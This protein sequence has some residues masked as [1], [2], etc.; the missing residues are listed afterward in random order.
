MINTSLIQWGEKQ[1][2][3]TGKVMGRIGMYIENPDQSVSKKNCEEA[4]FNIYVFF[5]AEGPIASKTHTLKINNIQKDVL[6]IE[7][8]QN[9]IYYENLVVDREL[10]DYN[11]KCDIVLSDV[12]NFYSDFKI[13]V[14]DFF[15]SN[16]SKDED[17]GVYIYGISFTKINFTKDNIK[18][19]EEEKYFNRKLRIY[20]DR[21]LHNDNFYKKGYE[22]IGFGNY[23]FNDN[24]YF[25]ITEDVEQDEINLNAEYK[26]NLYNITF[27]GCGGRTEDNLE[28]VTV[29]NFSENSIIP[30][31]TRSL[32]N[33]AGWG[34]TSFD[35]TAV[36]VKELDLKE[37]IK[38]YALWEPI[39]MKVTYD[40]GVADNLVTNKEE[41]SETDN[42]SLI[43]TVNLTKPIASEQYIF[44][45]WVNSNGDKKF[46]GDIL[47][48]D[49][50]DEEMS[51]IK[52]NIFIEDKYVTEQLV[53]QWE[54]PIYTATYINNSG[55][56]LTTQN[57]GY[58]TGVVE[59][60][61]EA[62]T[63]KM[64]DKKVAYKNGDK[65]PNHD[66]TLYAANYGKI[67][68]AYYDGISN[69][70][71]IT[72]EDEVEF[73]NA[74]TVKYK[75]KDTKNFAYSE[76]NTLKFFNYWQDENNNIYYA[77]GVYELSTTQNYS[78][79]AVYSD[80]RLNYVAS[81][82]ANGNEELTFVA[83]MFKET[84]DNDEKFLQANYNSGNY[85][86]VAEKF[87][88]V[89]GS[90]F[91][92]VNDEIIEFNDFEERISPTFL[93]LSFIDKNNI[94]QNLYLDLS[95]PNNNIYD[96]TDLILTI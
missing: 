29:E 91:I 83:G 60:D 52:N 50:L 7:I 57:Y 80:K 17:K 89:E 42:K 33:F 79:F 69:N 21:F 81:I 93:T 87:Q 92:K 38:L 5:Q 26:K 43:Q 62:W 25:E 72:D 34:L 59:G 36:T 76:N 96:E 49:Y 74:E 2:D 90:C 27:I 94:E 47:I 86:V 67:N 71:T 15:W 10:K 16:L 48:I 40:M 18:F 95:D 65:L 44:S 58:N 24:G 31:F 30:T 70:E 88:E 66:I 32:Y 73:C 78:I 4:I 82:E 9:L 8:G 45:H 22:L 56:E 6:P 11:L 55:T 35:K 12:K 1:L 84:D 19:D 20:K 75:F 41:F 28:E 64:G 63:I 54:K 68:I 46:P 51:I 13:S 14:D 53:A 61:Y 37:N 85:E 77:N 3:R 23:R 39:G